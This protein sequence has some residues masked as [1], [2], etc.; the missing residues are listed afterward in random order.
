MNREIDLMGPF[1]NYRINMKRF[2]IIIC[3]LNYLNQNI[4][5]VNDVKTKIIF[6]TDMGPDYD[7]I[8]AIAMLHALADNKECE[9][10]A[11]IASDAHPLIAPTID[12]YN[13]YF[14]KS[15]IPV[16]EAVKTA[17]NFLPKNNWNQKVLKKYPQYTV[18]DK[19][20]PSAIEVYRKTL[21]NAKDNSVTIVT[22]GFLSNLEVLLKSPADKYSNL[23]GLELIDRKVKK[24][25][26]MAGVFPS[27]SEFNINKDPL[28]AQYVFD[29]WPTK[30]LFSGF[31]I[32]KDIHTGQ[33]LS[34]SNDESSPVAWGYK[35]NGETYKDFE[36]KTRQSWDQT[37]VLVSI[38]DP[39]KYFYVLGP[40]EFSVDKNG[41]NF[42]NP[43]SG[44]DHYF[45]AHKYPY[46][47]LEKVID[48]LMEHQP[49]K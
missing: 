30:I 23:T 36:S 12:L 9:I 27:G 35:Y 16:G 11:C 41:H 18:K 21:A 7:D 44:K 4:A 14:N 3:F 39:E 8:G 48:E 47:Y 13:R 24:L 15:N 19:H 2:I 25:V 33:N 31:E 46:S 34:E 10:L 38:R 40:G 26:T 32:G 45:L 5:Q 22:V 42:W 29:N 43:K 20:Y 37:A 1:K 49:Q 17:P 28:P 6:D